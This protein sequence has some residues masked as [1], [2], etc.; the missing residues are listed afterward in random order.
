MKG[1]HHN[2]SLFCVHAPTEDS[3]NTVKEQF[4]EEWQKIQDC[5]PKH[6]FIILLGDMNAKIGLE[7]AHSSVTGK[8][9]LHT[10]SNSNGELICEYAAANN[11]YIMSTKFKHKG[12]WVAPDRNICY[13][14]D[15]VLVNQ[16]KS[17]MIQ[18]VR[19]LRRP[20]CDSDHFLVKIMMIQ[21]LIRMQQNNNTQ[22]NNGTG[23]IYK[24]KR[25]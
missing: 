1:K 14:I 15:H 20:N 6:D 23:R 12:T 18:D 22:K 10:E 17:S 16:H 7:D 13:Q 24:T 25:N 5:I 2:L 9:S 11:M 19:T 3:D 8:Y 4:F 21:T